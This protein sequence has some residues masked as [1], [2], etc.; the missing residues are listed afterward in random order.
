MRSGTK[1]SQRAR[2]CEGQRC[3]CFSATGYTPLLAGIYGLPFLLELPENYAL[4]AFILAC[5]GLSSVFLYLA[6]RWVWGLKAA[7][8]S[9][10]LWIIQTL[11]VVK[12]IVTGFQ[13]S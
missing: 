7:L 6:A 4:S 2:I 12:R 10:L 3:V 8:V 1:P 9:S 13:E 11:T 5:G